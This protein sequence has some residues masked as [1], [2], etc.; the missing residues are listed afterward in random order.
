MNPI[1]I[2]EINNMKKNLCTS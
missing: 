2:V 1:S